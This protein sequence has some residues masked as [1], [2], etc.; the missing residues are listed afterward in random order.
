MSNKI[1]KFLNS[2]ENIK[3]LTDRCNFFFINE[4]DWPDCKQLEKL[5]QNKYIRCWLTDDNNLKIKLCPI[6]EIIKI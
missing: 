2:L 1:E 6:C 3:C 4:D 5:W